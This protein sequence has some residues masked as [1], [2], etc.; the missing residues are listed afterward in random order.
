[1]QELGRFIFFF[2]PNVCKQCGLAFRGRGKYIKS[3]DCRTINKED[4]AAVCTKGIL[5]EA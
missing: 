4:R 1:M 5:V 3:F 2:G